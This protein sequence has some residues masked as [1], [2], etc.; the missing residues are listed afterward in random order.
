[1]SAFW[2]DPEYKLW[3]RCRFDFLPPHD[4]RVM[5]VIVDYKT[6]ADASKRAFPKSVDNFGY[7][8]QAAQYCDGWRAIYGTDPAFVFVAQ[9]TKPPYLVATYQLDAEALA[10]G[11]DAMN[12]AMEIWRDCRAAEAEEALYAW[13]GYSHEIETI[14]LP[15]WSSHREDFYA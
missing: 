10:I 12:R 1:M 15:R 7:H 14:A 3:K 2:I 11:R 9:E 6:C 4:P 5:P 13:P 8:V